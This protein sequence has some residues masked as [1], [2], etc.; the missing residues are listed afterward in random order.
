MRSRGARYELGMR[1]FAVKAGRRSSAFK[2]L[3]GCFQNDLSWL[4]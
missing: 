2:G 1:R 3:Q 4:R